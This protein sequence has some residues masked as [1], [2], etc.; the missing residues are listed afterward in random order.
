MIF[1]KYRAHS[2]RDGSEV[3][4]EEIARSERIERKI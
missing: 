2:W 4:S 1:L 3:R